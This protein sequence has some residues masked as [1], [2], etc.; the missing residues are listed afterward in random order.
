MF[1]RSCADALVV[2]RGGEDMSAPCGKK[3][4]AIISDNGSCADGAG[5]G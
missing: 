3:L 5:S 2:D 1:L 4:G